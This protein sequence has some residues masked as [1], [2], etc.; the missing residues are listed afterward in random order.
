MIKVSEPEKTKIV[1]IR[2]PIAVHSA[3]LAE[4]VRE[5]FVSRNGHPLPGRWLESKMSKYV[6]R[7]VGRLQSTG[8]NMRVGQ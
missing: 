3:L 1:A 6:H 7:A 8:A 2:V 4:A 5:G